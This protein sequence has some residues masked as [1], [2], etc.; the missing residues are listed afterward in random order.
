ME[1]YRRVNPFENLD[2][3]FEKNNQIQLDAL[4]TNLTVA[5]AGSNPDK[6]L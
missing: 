6:I 4:R 2:A 1:N 5:A 3:I